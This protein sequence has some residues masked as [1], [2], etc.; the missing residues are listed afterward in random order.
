ML[1]YLPTNVRNITIKTKG[2]GKVKAGI[3]VLAARRQRNRRELSEPD[4]PIKMTVNQQKDQQR[5]IIMQTVCLTSLSPLIDTFEIVHGLFTGFTTYFDKV[6]IVGQSDLKMIN[7]PMVSSY[8]IHMT[9]QLNKTNTQGC[10]KVAVF[11]PN[12]PHEPTSLAPV[13]ISCRHP[14]NDIVG[15]VLISHP[16]AVA[17]GKTKRNAA[18]H[19]VLRLRKHSSKRRA[20]AAIDETIESVC[21]NGGQCTCGEST[22]AVRCN[23]CQRS[24]PQSVRKEICRDGAFGIFGKLIEK[25][26]STISVGS[27]TA[28]YNI[29]K[30]HVLQTLM[31]DEIIEMRNNQI[32]IWLRKCNQRCNKDISINK[33]E[34]YF[35]IGDRN[36]LIVDTD[37]R[38][39]Y[40]LR[41]TD[42]FEKSRTQH[43]RATI[44]GPTQE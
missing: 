38:T 37:A 4:L 3:R 22:C 25:R 6:E 44:F 42:R 2:F 27:S 33:E 21:F 23:S 31:R 8:A 36:D 29:Y 11:P 12:H 18:V 20:R 35:V 19:A 32:E 10:Y 14:V 24:T 1:I 16:D 7:L 39:N 40:V 34:S 30:M 26:E 17:R 15:Q 28:I 9:V 5:D 43:C 41:L 13:E